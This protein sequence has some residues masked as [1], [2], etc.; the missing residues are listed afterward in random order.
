M[1][2]KRCQSGSS[3]VNLPQGSKQYWQGQYDAL[4][5][6]AIILRKFADQNQTQKQLNLLARAIEVKS[7]LM[8][9]R[10]KL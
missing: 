10:K 9:R 8:A 6:C 1:D 2:W 5:H 3:L 4:R 7:V